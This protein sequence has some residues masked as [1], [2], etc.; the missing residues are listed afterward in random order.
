VRCPYCDT[1]NDEPAQLC[2]KCGNELTRDP[3]LWGDSKALPAE[4]A[5]AGV[6]AA[7]KMW[8]PAHRNAGPQT[9]SHYVPPPVF[10]THLGWAVTSLLLCFLVPGVVIYLLWDIRFGGPALGLSLVGLAAILCSLMVRAKQA[11]GDD[12]RAFRYS[13]LAK[14][15]CWFSFVLGV[16]LYSAIFLRLAYGIGTYWGY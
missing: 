15:L 10:P 11:K 13:Q 1:Q 6:E 14:L 8:D 7:N 9:M 16:L 5:L 3:G 4:P 2:R 12:D